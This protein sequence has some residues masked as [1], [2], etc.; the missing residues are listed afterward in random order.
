MGCDATL[1]RVPSRTFEKLRRERGFASVAQALW[2]AN[3]R[4]VGTIGALAKTRVQLDRVWNDLPLLFEAIDGAITPRGSTA[5]QLRGLKP[6][7]GL[8]DLF[9]F[10][11]SPPQVMVLAATWAEAAERAQVTFRAW[12]GPS[13]RVDLAR[14]KAIFASYEF[15]SPRQ[16]AAVVGQLV[17]RL[18][19]AELPVEYPMDWLV[20]ATANF[21]QVLNE[22][23]KRDEGLLVLAS[24]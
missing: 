9:A 7:R 14:G 24:P 20:D 4:R 15:I 8:R 22:S 5:Y 10:T 1:F 23:A 2:V 11:V 13:T 17:E 3:T 6:I 21:V 12:T 16:S 18:V 19:S